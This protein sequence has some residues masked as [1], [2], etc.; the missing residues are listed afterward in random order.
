MLSK[1][2]KRFKRWSHVFNL[3]LGTAST[4]DKW[5]LTIPWA[6]SVHAVHHK[7]PVGS[8]F[9]AIFSF[10]EFGARQNLDRINIISI[11]WARS[12]QYQCEC[13]HLSK[14]SKRFK[15]YESGPTYFTNC[16][17]TDESELGPGKASTNDK[18]HSTIPWA[19]SCQ[20]QCACK[21]STQYS[22][23]AQTDRGWTGVLIRHTL[24]DNLQA[25]LS[26][27]FLRVV[28]L[29]SCLRDIVPRDWEYRQAN[30]RCFYMY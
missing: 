2:S 30:D 29:K 18:W 28:Q 7:I 12:C 13:K 25:S 27:D 17:V 6:T 3:D 19:T 9:N 22:T 8:R 14:Y 11:S 4:N 23:T 16:P 15:S 1:Y 24:K 10:S 21:I 20:Y 5:H 26:V